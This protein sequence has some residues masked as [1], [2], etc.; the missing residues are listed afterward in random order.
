MTPRLLRAQWLSYCPSRTRMV[1][2]VKATCLVW[3]RHILLMV[4][5]NEL[6][7]QFHHLISC[8]DFQCHICCNAGTGA[9]FGDDGSGVV[10]TAWALLGL[11]AG[12]CK[13][14]KAIE[15][16]VR[17][18]MKKQV[19]QSLRTCCYWSS[20]NCICVGSY[21]VVIGL[22]KVSLESSTGRV[23]SRTLLIAMC[24]QFGRWEDMPI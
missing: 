1:D 7:N 3:T 13:E 17:Y 18:L 21:L 4:V 15:R 6:S 19:S 10:N 20:S 23:A 5:T 16:G 2:G 8:H 14:T 24:S 11:M 22:K 9:G 12:G